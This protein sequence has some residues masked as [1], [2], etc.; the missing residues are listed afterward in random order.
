MAS[1]ANLASLT[2]SG[3]SLTPVHSSSPRLASLAARDSSAANSFDS[4][5]SNTLADAEPNGERVGR[6][7]HVQSLT[8]HMGRLTSSPLTALS[9]GRATDATMADT[10]ASG[11][12][13][14][15]SRSAAIPIS[16]ARSASRTRGSVC[17]ASPAS[18]ASSFGTSL[19]DGAPRDLVAMG[20]K[21]PTKVEDVQGLHVTSAGKY[22]K[23]LEAAGLELIDFRDLSKHLAPFYDAMVA[24]VRNP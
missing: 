23:S 20:A 21:A 24:E 17:G 15:A 13:Q 16:R 1:S 4:S 2:G 14:P 18:V 12:A 8:A 11:A 7:V 5:D 3:D 22:M 10:G 6:P 19:L 9:S